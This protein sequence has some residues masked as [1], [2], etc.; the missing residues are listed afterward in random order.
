MEDHEVNTEQRL[1]RLCGELV[2]G[3]GEVFRGFAFF[4]CGNISQTQAPPHFC[5]EAIL[6]IP[7]R[8]LN[9]PSPPDSCGE[10]SEAK[11]GFRAA[12]ESA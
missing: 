6:S 12:K 5:M 8:W 4:V 1:T 7:H 11:S 10:D 9:S 3:E 2:E